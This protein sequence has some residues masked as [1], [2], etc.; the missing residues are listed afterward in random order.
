MSG[1]L[2]CNPYLVI[3][4]LILFL[5]F[6][7]D[8]EVLYSQGYIFDVLHSITSLGSS[9]FIIPVACALPAVLDYYE[10]KQ[11]LNYRYKIMR[12]GRLSYATRTLIKG[13]ISGGIVIGAAL[14]LIFVSCFLAAAVNGYHIQWAD[15]SG[16]YGSRDNETIYIQL[17]DN[18]MGWLVLLLN[19]LMMVCS[20]MLWPCFGIILSVFIRNQ[21]LAV[22]FPFLL[23]RIFAYIYDFNEYLTPIGFHMTLGIVYE[24]YGGFLRVAIYMIS[25]FILGVIALML[26]M[27][28]MYRRGD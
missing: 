22:V 10:E 25:V 15:Y 12:S 16:W 18:G 14:I 26:N 17:F 27:S 23:F 19:T 6:W 2:K 21:K 24:P 8:G 7:L 1:R 4:I 28:Y 20:G 5:L 3:S 11:T 9:D 13:M